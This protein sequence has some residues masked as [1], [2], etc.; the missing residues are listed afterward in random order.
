MTRRHFLEAAGTFT[1]GA[2]S[3]TPWLIS[4]AE[5]VEPK[6]APPKWRGVNLGGWLVLE[7]WITPSVF[8][9]VDAGDEYTLG[10]KLGKRA[11][12]ERLSRHR[13]KWIT[14]DDLRWLAG[15]GINA[16]RLPVTYGALE[17]NPP[18]I[19]ATESLGWAF[20]TA[21]AHKLG[22]LLDL[23]G[24]PG[25][26]NGWDHSG[27]AGSLG[28]HTNAKNIEHSLEILEGLAAFCKNYDNLLGIELVNE[29]HADVPTTVLRS[30]Y[31]KG[32]ERIRKHVPAN[33][34]AVVFHDG[35]R[36]NDW[37]EFMPGPNEQ[38]II[39]DRHLYQCFTAEDQKRE[40]HDQ[41]GLA[42]KGRK[43][44]LERI[45]KRHRWIVGEWSCGLPN[46]ALGR[47]KGLDLDAAM[48][49]YGAA[50]LL[51]YGRTE[52]WFFWTYRTEKGGGWSFRD[53]VERGWLPDRFG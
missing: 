41:I 31:Q 23:H 48:R 3:G 36:P 11:A 39:M 30:F 38:N 13:E 47:G 14:E 1:L 15:R 4:A 42:V 18:F 45:S 40:I 20:R 44:E 49:A 27:K 7:R 37:S 24:V 32:Y 26:Q 5:N 6:A 16:V 22:V 29:P 52:G 50:Q 12:A 2:F 34:A 25:S 51:T 46:K 19:T 10:E 53:C 21:Q 8:A 35:F 17:E 9:G 33:R 43:E 28:W